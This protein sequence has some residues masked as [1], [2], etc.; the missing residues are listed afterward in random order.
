METS[1]LDSKPTEAS[2]ALKLERNTSVNTVGTE[3]TDTAFGNIQDEKTDDSSQLTAQVGEN[4]ASTNSKSQ[5]GGRRPKKA[6]PDPKN[7]QAIPSYPLDR[8]K[9]KEIITGIMRRV[10]P[11]AIVIDEDALDTMADCTE[12]FASSISCEAFTHV[13]NSASGTLAPS[14][15]LYSLRALGYEDFSSA[16]KT[17]IC[18]RDKHLRICQ[19]C[20]EER[21]VFESPKPV[22]ASTAKGRSSS[23]SAALKKRSNKDNK[24]KI[25][26][27]ETNEEGTKLLSKN[28]SASNLESL[29]T[30][31]ASRLPPS[32]KKRKV[33]ANTEDTKGNSDGIGATGNDAAIGTATKVAPRR[34]A[35]RKAQQIESAA[36]NANAGA[37][38]ASTA[39]TEARPGETEE[40]SDTPRTK[41]GP[42]K[43]F[44]NWLDESYVQEFMARIQEGMNASDPQ[45]FI[46]NLA[47]EMKIP[48]NEVAER[49][50]Q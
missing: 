27:Q 15:Y 42:K 6:F 48:V 25:R 32:G 21:I 19:A 43:N 41:K 4:Y 5:R 33:A 1:S 2:N 14:D 44:R 39:A 45:L 29:D 8:E 12:E 10:L 50:N 3:N 26:G 23:S 24:E 30:A 28:D 36:T 49:F 40:A 20:S 46:R 13:D 7:P 47:K 37:N 11:P 22:T 9:F 35:K 16:V 17:F 38:S 34:K 18:Q 31:Q